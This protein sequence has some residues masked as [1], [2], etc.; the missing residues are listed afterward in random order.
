M[1]WSL[2]E[3]KANGGSLSQS[4]IFKQEDYER[5]FREQIERLK[6]EREERS[7]AEAG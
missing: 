7:G 5:V 1:F 6:R 2:S 3:A 4:Q